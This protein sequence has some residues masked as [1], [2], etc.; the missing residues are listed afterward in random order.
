MADSLV[1]TPTRSSDVSVYARHNPSCR[2]T[3]ERKLKDCCCP[4]WLYVK[5]TQERRSARTIYWKVAEQEA[6]KIRDSFDPVKRELD[7]L[8]KTKAR[9]IVLI[10][11]A[12]DGW[13]ANK[14]A[15]N[16]RSETLESYSNSLRHMRDYFANNR[17]YHLHD[18]TP[19]GLA[20]WKTT[21]PDK[22]ISSKKKRRIHAKAFFRFSIDAMHWL[23]DDPSTGLTKI[24]GKEEVPTIPFERDQYA[25]VIDATYVYDESL[26]AYNK[27]SQCHE[28]GRRLRAFIQTMRWGGLGVRDAALLQRSRLSTDD[29]LKVRR[30]K[31]GT[32]VTVLLPHL[33]A[34]D[35]RNVP[36]GKATHADYFFWSGKSTGRSTVGNWNRSLDRL[37][38]LVKWPN[39]TGPIDGDGNPVKPHS[40]MFRN[41]FAKEFLEAEQGDIYDLA[42]LLGHTSVKTTEK[43][44]KAFV[45]A[46]AKRLNEKV[47]ASFAAQGAPGYA[48]PRKPMRGSSAQVKKALPFR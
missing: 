6:Q 45:P 23:A 40:H 17:I 1:L 39:G 28:C 32:W 3:S 5:A 44:Y 43:H 20:G 13:L 18:I 22:A 38:K 21:W 48:T 7:E 31:T 4:K 2:N 26:T 15:D 27:E 10:E 33:V 34:E 35:L 24:I 47:L 29:L 19:A 14:K 25:A 46:R 36:A 37:W 9:D 16:A 11:D 41:T 42:E 12:I 30:T 8:R